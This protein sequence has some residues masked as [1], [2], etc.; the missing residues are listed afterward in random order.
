LQAGVDKLSTDMNNAKTRPMELGQA[1]SK[2]AGAAM[3]VGQAIN[4]VK[5]VLSVFNDE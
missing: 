5:G 1:F 3:A 4:T 2:A